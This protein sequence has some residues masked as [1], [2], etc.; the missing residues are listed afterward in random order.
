MLSVLVSA[1]GPGHIQLAY[2]A[3]S[4][5]LHAAAKATL[6]FPCSRS[7][8]P[9]SPYFPPSIYTFLPLSITVSFLFLSPLLSL[10]CFPSF[11][12]PLPPRAET[13]HHPVLL[14]LYLLLYLFLLKSQ[15][16]SFAS[17]PGRAG[18]LFLGFY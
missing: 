8:L 3:P 7:F 11:S 9:C 16:S 2:E 5:L 6:C 18:L 1:C 12:L 15:S 13:P 14:L 10:P 4:N 17:R